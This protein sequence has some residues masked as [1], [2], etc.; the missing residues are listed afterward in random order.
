MKLDIPEVPPSLNKVLRMHWAKRSK[1][2]TDWA[3]KARIA[4]HGQHEVP[5]VVKQNVKVTLHHPRL[6]D[7]DNAY[8]A[9]KVLVDCL[10]GLGII[11]DDT[12]RWLDLDVQQEKCK[13]RDRHTTIEIEPCDLASAS[14]PRADLNERR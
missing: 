14:S 8:G 3:W 1:L 2:A 10:R 4:F 12:S 13:H 9:C 11:V 5:I 6:Y 7:K